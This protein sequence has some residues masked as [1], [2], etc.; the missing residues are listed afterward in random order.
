MP[1]TIQFY[2]VTTKPDI[3]LSSVTQVL[4]YYFTASPDT[5]PAADAE[6]VAEC[7]MLRK[8]L[9]QAIVGEDFSSEEHI[10]TFIQSIKER[11]NKNKRKDI[12]QTNVF[13]KLKTHWS[14]AKKKRLVSSCNCLRVDFLEIM[15][16]KTF[17][18][19]LDIRSESLGALISKE[20]F[21]SSCQSILCY[22]N[23]I[24]RM[25]EDTISDIK[26][27]ILY[28]IEWALGLPPSPEVPKKYRKPPPQ[29]EEEALEELY[30]TL[31]TPKKSKLPLSKVANR[32]AVGFFIEKL[33]RNP[34]SYGLDESKI[35]AV[36]KWANTEIFAER[37][38]FN[39]L[40]Q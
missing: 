27:N 33:A 8:S 12:L 25:D 19:K 16:D 20:P 23:I 38:R 1:T 7:R 13:R 11:K 39:R 9:G 14:M 35:D 18:T 29:S 10:S 4:H 32:D 31:N 3:L 40:Q 2:G 37:G 28:K 24:E 36:K 30:S 15:E 22:E 5:F 17:W 21:A 26:K 34:S 6:N